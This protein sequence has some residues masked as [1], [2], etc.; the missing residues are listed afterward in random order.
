[1][2]LKKIVYFRERYLGERLNYFQL[3]FKARVIDSSFFLPFYKVTI[4][5]EIDSV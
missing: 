4:L 3:Y 1:M 5:Q 2:F